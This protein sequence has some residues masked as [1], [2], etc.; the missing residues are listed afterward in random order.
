VLGLGFEMR[1]SMNYLDRG[2]RL[3]RTLAPALTLTLALT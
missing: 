2:F 1:T 3:G